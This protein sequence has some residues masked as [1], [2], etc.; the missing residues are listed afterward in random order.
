MTYRLNAAQVEA[1]RAIGSF[2]TVTADA[3][4]EHVY[5]GNKSAFERDLRQLCRQNLAI[6]STRE[7]RPGERFV[8][9]TMDA[10]KLAEARL[11][12]NPD[13]RIYAGA[14]KHRELDHDVAIYAMYHKGLETIASEGGSPTRVLLDYEFKESLNRDIQEAKALPRP[15]TLARLETIAE[16]HHLKVVDEHI[17]VPDLRIEYE[18]RDGDMAHLDLEFVTP[19]YRA[20][21]I[22]EKARAGF[23]LYGD[24]GSGGR[25]VRDEY[26]S[27]AAEIL[28]L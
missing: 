18:T 1:V 19:N 10:K 25:R 6:V 26:P 24:G 5:R 15:D 9:L 12:L 28:S 17:P 23:T 2:R 21:A 13:Q 8:S 16:A 14:L 20:D 22:A 27:L 4:M 7:G 3:L 11:I